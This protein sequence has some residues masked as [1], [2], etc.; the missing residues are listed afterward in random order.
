MISRIEY[1]HNKSFIHR[2]IKVCLDN[3][4]RENF[5]FVRFL[6]RQFSDGYR[7]PLQ[8]TLSDRFRSGQKIPGRAHPPA[9]PVQGRQK[10]DRYGAV[11]LHQRPLG[12]RAVPT[13]RH[14]VYG[15]C[16]HVLQPLLSPMAGTQ[17]RY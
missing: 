15:L 14:G 6:A 7:S 13:R 4:C 17:G 2:D 11:R 9:H 10:L 3:D 8:Q 5:Y 1:V 12:N 16:T